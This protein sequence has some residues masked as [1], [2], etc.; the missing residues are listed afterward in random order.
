MK[1]EDSNIVTRKELDQLI[2]FAIKLENNM[3][4]KQTELINDNKEFRENY[5]LLTPN[6]INLKKKT[7]C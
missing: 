6:L 5:L 4:T 1:M 3:I 7:K 2:E